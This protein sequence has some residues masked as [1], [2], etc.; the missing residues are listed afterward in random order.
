MNIGPEEKEQEERT[1]IYD[2]LICIRYAQN[3]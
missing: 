1:G 3:H 2:G